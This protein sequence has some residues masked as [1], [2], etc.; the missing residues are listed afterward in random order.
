MPP[1]FGI[2]MILFQNSYSSVLRVAIA[3]SKI[4]TWLLTSRDKFYIIP[5]QYQFQFARTAYF[6]LL[7]QTN[8]NSQSCHRQSLNP[9][10]SS[11]LPSYRSSSLPHIQIHFGYNG[12]QRSC[13][14]GMPSNFYLSSV[15]R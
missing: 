10:K 9:S 4:N 14:Q 13:S 12:N 15:S 6:P 8:F 1:N 2:E 3:H 7:S 11:A 5:Q